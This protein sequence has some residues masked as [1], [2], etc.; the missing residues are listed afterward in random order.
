MYSDTDSRNKFLAVEIVRAVKQDQFGV[1]CAGL[2]R[3]AYRTALPEYGDKSVG[4]RMR[5]I[6]IIIVTSA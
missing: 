1:M 6:L 2:A 5:L 3:A 4:Q